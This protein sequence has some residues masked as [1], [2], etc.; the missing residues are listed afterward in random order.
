MDYKEAAEYLDETLEKEARVP[1]V[2]PRLPDPQTFMNASV[3]P[4]SFARSSDAVGAKLSGMA[5]T[6]AD[7]VA[8]DIGRAMN[9]SKGAVRRSS[10]KGAKPSTKLMKASPK[11]KA[12]GAGAAL[13]GAGMAAGSALSK[14][15]EKAA[16]EILDELYLE[17]T[18]GMGPIGKSM[19]IG[20]GIGAASGA[21]QGFLKKRKFE[22]DPRA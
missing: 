14:Q 1:F 5:Q 13:L 18:A 12:V 20:A 11:L 21:T 22:K 19:L 8:S 4:S 16:S 2:D 3:K 6:K 17:K 7:Q 9:K 10:L 15:K